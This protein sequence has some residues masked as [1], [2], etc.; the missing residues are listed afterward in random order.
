MIAHSLQFLSEDRL[1]YRSQRTKELDTMLGDLHCEIRDL[2]TAVMTQLQ[3]KVVEKGPVLYQVMEYSAQLDCLISLALASR[4]FSYCRPTLST[5]HSI[6]IRDCRHPLVEMCTGMYV[7]NPVLSSADEGKMKV[8]TG[9]NSCGKSVYLKQVG[10]AVF[11]A[12]V[13]SNVPASEAH[14]GLVDGI[15]T[16]MQSR[17]SV[18]VGLSTF[19]IDLNQMA[20]AVNN[21]TERSLVLIDEFG[22]GTNTVDGLSLLASSLRHWLHPGQACPHVFI[23]TNFH[24]LFQLNLLPESPLLS[25]QTLETAV[26]GEELVFFY[27]LREGV[28]TSSYAANIATL[29][30]M[31][32]K[33]V[34][35]GVETLETAVDGEEL[36]FFYQLREGVSTSSYAANIATLAGMPAKIVQRGVETLETAVDGEELVFFYQLREGVSTSS[37]A[38]NIATLAGMPA[39]IVQRGVETLETAVDGEELV[40]FYQLREGVSTS[41][42]A[43]NIATLA[44]MP[45]KIVSDTPLHWF[46][47]VITGAEQCK[48]LVNRFLHLDLEDLSVD[49]QEFMRTEVLLAAASVL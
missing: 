46:C 21:A 30:G 49:L 28:S 42:Y 23:S 14:I 24:S 6:S 29:A 11:M 17:E 10:L 47:N 48:E 39:K 27:Q 40:F 35:R 43:A 38:A 31:P 37:Y 20:C 5:E 18:S 7:S 4:E 26:D 16:R 22:K 32:A 33:I 9:P 8:I 13:G 15:Y 44:G 1:H 45:A 41:S 36:V 3:E 25:Y 34:Q 12:L 19:M 2:E